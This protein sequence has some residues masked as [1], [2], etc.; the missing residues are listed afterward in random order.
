M[1][2]NPNVSSS[3]RKCRKAYFNATSSEKHKLMTAPLSKELRS[4]YNVRAVPIRKDDEVMV[5]RGYQHDR[6]GKVTAV[7]R[8]KDV[9]HIERLAR[10]KANGQT[11]NIGVR[12]SKV[13]I[14]KLKLDKDRKAMLERK[15]RATAKGKYKEGD[16]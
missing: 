2:L 11:V 14:T 8:K 9:I 4:K 10:D 16:M 7:Y 15:N 3:R 1:K 6:E 13:V 12:P 5:V